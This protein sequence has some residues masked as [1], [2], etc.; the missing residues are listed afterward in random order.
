MSRRPT[1]ATLIDTWGTTR[2]AMLYMSWAVDNLEPFARVLDI[3]AGDGVAADALP[4]TVAYSGIDIG[5]DIYQRT[6]RVRY[7]EDIDALRTAIADHDLADLVTL[8]DVLEH[9][10]DFTGLFRDGLLRSQQYVFVSLPNEL[11]IEARL[12][13]LLG[14]HTLSHGLN[15]LGAE[16]GHK[17]QW[18]ISFAPARDVLT[19]EAEQFGFGPIHEVFIR[20]LPRTRWKRCLVRALEMPLPNT[21]KAHGLGF[22]FG[23]TPDAQ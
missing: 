17:H 21:L 22:V 4:P 23:R 15:L 19:R 9:T 6:G 10:A 18:L 3:G 5:A 11:N 1:P 13:F 16:P 8:F 12:R 2:K 20:N 7:I 14:Q